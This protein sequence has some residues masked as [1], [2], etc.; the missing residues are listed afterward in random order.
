MAGAESPLILGVSG[1]RGI[2]GASLTPEVASRYAAAFGTWLGERVSDS[3]PP[4]VV[5]GMDGRAGG[6][7][8][9]FA[10]LS[11]L[12]ATGCRVYWLGVA[13]TPSVGVSCDAMRA[14]GAVVVTASHNPQ[15]WNGLKLLVRAQ[16]HALAPASDARGGPGV[17]PVECSAPSE[18]LAR[19][20]VARFAEQRI[21]WVDGQR[22]GDVRWD[23]DAVA[24][25]CLSVKRAIERL[26]RRTWGEMLGQG[27]VRRVVTDSVNVSSSL[28]DRVFFA[29]G[30]I[31]CV[32]LGASE[33]GVFPHA[34]EPTAENLSGPGGLTEVVPGVGADI[35]FAQDPD[36]DRLAIV[37][38]RGWYIGEEYTLALCALSV[39]SLVEDPTG[40]VVVANLSTSRMV[41]DVAGR[42]GARVERTAVG[43]ANVVERMKSLA[44]SGERVVLGGEGNGGVIWPEV[45]YVRDSIG[46]MG[47]VLALMARRSQR[48]SELVAEIDSMGPGEGLGYAIEKRKVP[49][50]SREDAAPAVEALA[51]HFGRKE[52]ATVDRQDGV[53]VDLG[54]EGAWVHVRA[55]N[56]EPI[57]RLIAEASSR[58]RASAILDE[59][60]G[61][62]SR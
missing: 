60:G 13:T 43:E 34:P 55:S 6:D 61:L 8:I 33:S 42:F 44:A 52:G 22:T 30:P 1:L 4:L 49:I 58:E 37:D 7:S 12:L 62:I 14:D 2:V 3:G 45:V 56:T 48:V 18:E 23:N 19:D 59:V 27:A 21:R 25:H 31:E 15:A 46:A 50:R 47:L 39:L 24:K 41:D 54:D 35:G 5:V 16:S 10:A 17:A 32:Q 38:E 20:L 29:S 57:M 28:I 53:R 40:S 36:G 11:G 9:A 51:A 26:A